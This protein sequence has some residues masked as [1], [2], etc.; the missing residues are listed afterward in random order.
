MHSVY[1]KHDMLYIFNEKP[2]LGTAVNRD[3]KIET[4]LN[5]LIRIVLAQLTELKCSL[6]LPPGSLFATVRKKKKNCR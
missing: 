1:I 6:T 2:S 5:D 3:L 4:S